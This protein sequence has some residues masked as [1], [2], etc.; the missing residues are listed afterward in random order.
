MPDLD[1]GYFLP[2]L[3]E[4]MTIEKFEPLINPHNLQKQEKLKIKRLARKNKHNHPGQHFTKLS[5]DSVSVEYGNKLFEII[6]L[7][8]SNS[9]K[10]YSLFNQYSCNLETK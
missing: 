8:K 6:L 2:R 4:D 7:R 10:T 1:E 9:A 3:S 5:K